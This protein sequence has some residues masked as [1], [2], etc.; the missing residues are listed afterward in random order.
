MF[1]K[2]LFIIQASLSFE[3]RMG[4]STVYNIVRDVCEAIWTTLQP[5]FGQMPSSEEEWV[6]VSKE[7]EERWNFPHCIGAIDGK[8]VVIQAPHNCGSEFYNYKGTH[9][10]V[11][12]AMC[13]AHYRFL[14]VDISDAGRHNDSGVFSN[15]ELGRA[16][17]AGTLSLPR[18]K[19]LPGFLSTP[20]PYVIVGDEAFPLKA[21]PLETISWP[22][23]P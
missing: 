20:L 10:V 9:S 5:E 6:G 23:S 13:D 12:L 8:H 21:L 3:F 18:C 7:Y 1:Y 11:L 17:E 16:L 15:S 4:K 2:V 22:A 19:P 14:A